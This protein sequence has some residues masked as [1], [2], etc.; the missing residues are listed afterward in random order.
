[1][2]ALTLSG[3]ISTDPYFDPQSLRPPYHAWHHVE[4]DIDD[5]QPI[6]GTDLT[7]S[8]R[9]F[10]RYTDSGDIEVQRV[11]LLNAR[12]AEDWRRGRRAAS[13]PF[14]T[15]HVDRILARLLLLDARS[16]GCRRDIRDGVAAPQDD[17]D[18]D[19]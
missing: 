10:V 17:R 9:A 14:S 3:R 16:A 6:A 12:T 13:R 11:E 2:P 8:Y 18:Q 7:I 5:R 15:G 1:M 4:V 19:F